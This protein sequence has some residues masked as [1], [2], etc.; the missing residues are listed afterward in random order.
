MG[1]E[2]RDSLDEQIESSRRYVLWLEER[3]KK[4]RR[5]LKWLMEIKEE[6][7]RD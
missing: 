5:S 3:L 2:N 1:E 7:G 6:H 4:A